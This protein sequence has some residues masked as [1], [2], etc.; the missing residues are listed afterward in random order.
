LSGVAAGAWHHDADDYRGR[1][2]SP[3]V[4]YSDVLSAYSVY[5]SQR[6]EPVM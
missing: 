4:A 3:A 5:S 2:I 6:R 1:L